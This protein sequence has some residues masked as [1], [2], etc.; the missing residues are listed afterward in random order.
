NGEYDKAA[1]EMF[2][3]RHDTSNEHAELETWLDKQY[4]DDR[5]G[6]EALPV[7]RTDDAPAK[8]Y[9]PAKTT[10]ENLTEF[11]GRPEPT[12]SAVDENG[13]MDLD[14]LAEQQEG[15]QD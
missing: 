15:E 13:I 1:S 6:R 11:M 8:D 2:A 14:I 4:G 10:Q 12:R 7:T 3:S 9:D 5:S